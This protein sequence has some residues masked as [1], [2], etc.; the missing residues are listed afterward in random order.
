MPQA[1]HH[2]S[3]TK[4]QCTHMFSDKTIGLIWPKE[5]N[6]S[7]ACAASRANTFE[8]QWVMRAIKVQA[9]SELKIANVPTVS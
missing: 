3:N 1:K 9:A 4:S 8:E 5:Q 2:I 7:H 6:I